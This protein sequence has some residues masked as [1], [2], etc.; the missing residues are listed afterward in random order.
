MRIDTERSRA[1]PEGVNLSLRVAGPPVRLVAWVMDLF[2]LMAA[3]VVLAI[4]AGMLASLGPGLYFLFAF[5]LMWFYPVAF[6]VLRRGAT[7]GKAMLGLQVVHDDGTPVGLASSLLRNLLRFADFLPF[8][9]GAG[10]IS[11][12]LSRDF[13]RLG[14]LAAGTL[15]IYRDQEGPDRRVPDAPPLPPPIALDRREQR[16][17]I[18]FGARLRSWNEERRAELA[19]TAAPLTGATGEDGVTR[20]LGMA[21]WLLGRR[22]EKR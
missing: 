13:Q 3:Q 22:Q 15:V 7:P 10:L 4:L 19:A 18:D 20:L 21:N 1:T 6:E 9:Y 12:L 14:D 17:V 11:M 16:A 2:I 8:A 5:A